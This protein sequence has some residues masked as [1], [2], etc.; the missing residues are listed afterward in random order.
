MP[1]Q[2]AVLLALDA[3]GDKDFHRHE[4]DHGTVSPKKEQ[5]LDPHI[6]ILETLR[7]IH[8]PFQ[9]PFDAQQ[10]NHPPKQDD[11]SDQGLERHNQNEET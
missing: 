10:H 4:L 9:M 11:Q 2:T 6:P 5:R 3:K 1:D 8:A 7:R